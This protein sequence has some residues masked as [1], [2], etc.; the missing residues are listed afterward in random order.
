MPIVASKAKVETPDARDQ[1]L[2]FVAGHVQYFRIDVMSYKQRT[3]P[4]KITENEKEGNSEACDVEAAL[5]LENDADRRTLQ[6]AIIGGLGG[7]GNRWAPVWG[8]KYNYLQSTRPLRMEEARG[9]YDS[10]RG[11]F[12]NWYRWTIV[13]EL[14]IPLAA[15][16]NITSDQKPEKDASA[17]DV[18]LSP[19]KKE[20]K[21]PKKEVPPS[22]NQEKTLTNE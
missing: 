4:N 18:E 17:S 14:L 7:L 21:L 1:L 5:D 16:T 19:T 6:A 11:N 15:W 8:K 13:L 20:T 2:N 10:L 9:D 3:S 12:A 22:P